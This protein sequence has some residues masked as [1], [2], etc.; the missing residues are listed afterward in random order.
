MPYRT[1]DAEA[2]HAMQ[3]R[4]RRWHGP[5]LDFFWRRPWRSPSRPAVSLHY[6][7]RVNLANLSGWLR[8]AHDCSDPSVAC[9]CS[10]GFRFPRP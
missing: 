2:I 9:S 5:V 6:P 7:I 3:R 8:N 1:L 4:L 10:G